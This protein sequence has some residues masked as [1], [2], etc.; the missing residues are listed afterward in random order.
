[1]ETD[2]IQRRIAEINSCSE[3]N[4][5]YPSTIGIDSSGRA[6]EVVFANLIRGQV[7]LEKYF[8]NRYK[9][10]RKPKINGGKYFAD[11]SNESGLAKG[12][13]S[14]KL[15]SLP[16]NVQNIFG[17]TINLLENKNK[18]FKGFK[19]VKLEKLDFAENFS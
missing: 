8:K 10:K 16:M 2:Y 12:R 15:E 11:F 4:P 17:S 19:I 14:K 1:M 7:V 6:Y 3:F 5:N 13:S 18:F 9:I